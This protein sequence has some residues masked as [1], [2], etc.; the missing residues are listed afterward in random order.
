[1][2]DFRSIIVVSVALTVSSCAF[3]SS[4]PPVL[5]GYEN[6]KIEFGLVGQSAYA[7]QKRIYFIQS[8]NGLDWEHGL[9]TSG[10]GIRVPPGKYT[11][12]YKWGYWNQAADKFASVTFEAKPGVCYQPWFESSV[13][14][15]K[16]GM[17]C[18]DD[19]KSIGNGKYKLDGK[20]CEPQYVSKNKHGLVMK[21][22]LPG[23]S[24]NSNLCPADFNKED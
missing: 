15:E 22:F 19:Y 3:L 8:I 1:M 13:V 18:K 24:E 17:N 5:P 9:P 12:L 11:I 2:G 14:S 4:K 16:V 6:K 10:S 20:I 21:E 7:G 23:D